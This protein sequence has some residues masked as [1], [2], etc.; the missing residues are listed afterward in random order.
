MTVSVTDS[1]S[2]GVTGLHE[3]RMGFNLNPCEASCNNR[4]SKM[5]SMCYVYHN[6]TLRPIAA[7]RTKEQARAFILRMSRNDFKGM[8]WKL[9]TCLTLTGNEWIA[10][11]YAG[12]NAPLA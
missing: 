4:E 7:F 12:S 5:L 8:W 3:K 9:E 11:E 1:D 2:Y 10:S 6:T